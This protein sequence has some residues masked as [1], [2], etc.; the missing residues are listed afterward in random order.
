MLCQRTKPLSDGELD[1][2]RERVKEMLRDMA[3]DFPDLS[4][5]DMRAII[6]ADFNDRQDDPFWASVPLRGDRITAEEGFFSSC[7]WLIRLSTSTTTLACSNEKSPS[8]YMT[9][10]GFSH[11]SLFTDS[12]GLGLSGQLLCWLRFSTVLLA[13]ANP[14]VPSSSVTTYR[15]SVSAICSAPVAAR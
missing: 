7:C 8:R 4:L 2:M 14:T 10:R 1:F 6:E 11:R 3:K 9:E 13:R 12:F 5:D 15:P